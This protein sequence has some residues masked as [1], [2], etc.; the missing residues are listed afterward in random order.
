MFRHLTLGTLTTIT[1]ACWAGAI[2]A[3][4]QDNV[5]AAKAHAQLPQ[6]LH[7]AELHFAPDS[8]K[9]LVLRYFSNKNEPVL[10][11]HDTTKGREYYH[12]L[13][14]SDLF[15]KLELASDAYG[16]SSAA[17]R[18][19]GIRV[20][21]SPKGR[22]FL[23]SSHKA[24]RLWE[25]TTK[26]LSAIK[27]YSVPIEHAGSVLAVFSRDGKRLLT[28]TVLAGKKVQN[29]AQYQVRL[30]EVD[31]GN[32]IGEPA[33]GVALD[34]PKLG[35]VMK[36]LLWAPDEKTVLMAYGGDRQEAKYLHF[37]DGATL[38]PV[39]EPLPAPGDFHQFS[40][41][42]KTLLVISQA[43]AGLW[44][45]ANRKLISKLPTGG[46]SRPGQPSTT[47]KHH[48]AVPADGVRV[49]FAK[50]KQVELWDLSAEPPVKKQVLEHTQTVNW[51][52]M[53][54]DGK[55][56]ATWE[57]P[58]VGRI[59]VWDLETGRPFLKVPLARAT[60]QNEWG[61]SDGRLKALEFS[62]DGRLLAT[63]TDRD[64]QLWSLEMKK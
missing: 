1:Y 47:L 51:V 23:T 25:T 46:K 19:E 22:I 59:L 49:L 27:P 58:F 54:R 38:Q 16:S 55:L 56:A 34:N 44:D 31:T 26:G 7:A 12:S 28:A 57:G 13:V 29:K 2:P 4:Q 9:L 42:G 62:P 64:V 36:T 14:G 30:W 21:F 37:L 24:V 32:P 33:T 53:S 43:E 48:F 15:G 52:A 10:S 3:Q 35:L 63:V 11:V 39:G 61:D 5:P 50:G 6:V 45:F 17:F 41:D 60:Y 40:Q 20:A 18:R 8:S